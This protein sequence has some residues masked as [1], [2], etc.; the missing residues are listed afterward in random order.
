M[1]LPDQFVNY[2][3][4]GGYP[5]GAAIAL[6]LGAIIGGSEY[7]WGTMKT[8]YTQGPGRLTTWAGRVA[9]FGAMIAILTAT[10]FAF[11]AASSVVVAVFQGHTIGT[12]PAAIDFAKGF[13]AVWLVFAANG[14]IGLALGILIRHSTAALG[15]G[16]VYVLAVEILAVNFIDGLDN[17]AY[18]WIGNLFAGQNSIALLQSFTSPTFGHSPTPAIGAEQTVLVLCGYVVGLVVVAAA[19][20]RL[21]DVT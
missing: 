20:L 17:G 11:G 21:R 9:V 19:A 13:G 5:L 2:I 16:L 7:S 10:L 12:W 3:M 18:N 14:A 4:G 15:I 6:V 1:L 8:M